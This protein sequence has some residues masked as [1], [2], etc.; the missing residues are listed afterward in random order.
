[1]QVLIYLY[2]GLGTGFYCNKKGKSYMTFL[3]IIMVPDALLM[4]AWLTGVRKRWREFGYTVNVRRMTISSYRRKRRSLY[5]YLF[6]KGEDE[7]QLRSAASWRNISSMRC[8]VSSPEE[9]WKYDAQ[10]EV[11][12]LVMK[13]CVECLILLLRQNEFRGRN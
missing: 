3:P 6:L 11:F 7:N 12:H 13:H 10:F 8:S 5:H 9:N 4:N 2:T 1:M